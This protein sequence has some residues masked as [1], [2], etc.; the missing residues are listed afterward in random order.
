MER[1][2]ACDAC[3]L[4]HRWDDLSAP[5][6]AYL[7]GVYL[8][9]GHIRAQA[10]SYLLRLSLDAAYPGI[11]DEVA[12]AVTIVSGRAPAPRPDPAGKHC[13]HLCSTWRAW[14]CLFPQHGAGRKHD[15]PIHLHD[16]Q[17][18][19]VES[20][21]EPLLRGLIHSD[22]W[23]GLNRVRAKGRDYA[24]PRYQFSN[25]SDDIRRIFTDAGDLLGIAWRPWGRWHIS[26]ARRDAV[27]RMD[28][29]IGP[30][31]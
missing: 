8:G 9:D 13:V 29:F 30:K 4:V 18:Q 19:L 23:R 24:Y 7:L 12:A 17:Q 5:Q 26:V 10:R 2:R 3:G 25:R 21:P 22:G 1:A 16:W 20:Q 15:R 27:E 11:V 28:E 31:R 14:P 6:Y